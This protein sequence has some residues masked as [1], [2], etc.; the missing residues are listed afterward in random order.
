M[1]I[2]DGD[3]RSSLVYFNQVT[4]YQSLETGHPMLRAAVKVGQ[5]GKIDYS[6]SAQ[7]AF[8]EYAVFLHLNQA[9]DCDHI[10]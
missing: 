1:Q 8:T 9:S 4:M 3:G 7:Q 5:S 6:A 2:G 10:K